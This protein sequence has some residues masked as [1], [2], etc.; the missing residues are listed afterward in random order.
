MKKGLLI[1]LEGPEGCGKTTQSELL[2]NYLRSKS[3]ST[4]KTREPGGT[5]V[6]EDIRNILL[7]SDYKNIDFLCE[8]LLYNA[9]RAQ[10][11]K[12]VIKSSLESGKIVICDRFLDATLAYQGY[13]RGIKKKVIFTLNKI[14]LGNLLPDLTLTFDLNPEEG[15]KRALKAKKN[16]HDRLE[17]ESFFFHQKVQQ[18]YLKIAKVYP[19]RVK[20][21]LADKSIEEVH[22]VVCSYVDKLIEKCRPGRITT[23]ED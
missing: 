5:K 3:F 17:Q 16:T 20:L 13:G 6:G 12:E 21:I 2:Y 11:L 22:K 8:F 19:E 10:L 1:T 15:L 18:G 9:A 7:N 23:N 4:I 14:V